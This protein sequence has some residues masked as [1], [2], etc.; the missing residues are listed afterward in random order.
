[1]HF[2]IPQT[3]THPFG[4]GF[5][6]EEV[7]KKMQPQNSNMDLNQQENIAMKYRYAIW[8]NP[9]GLWNISHRSI[10]N[11][12][13]L[14]TF[15]K[16]I[17]HTRSVF[18]IAE[19]YFTRRRRIS[20]KK[21]ITKAIVFFWWEMV[22]TLRSP[23][24]RMFRTFATK[25]S[26]SRLHSPQNLSRFCGCFDWTTFGGSH[27][28]SHIS[29]KQKHTHSGAFLFGGRWWIRTTEGEASRF[30]VCP[31]WPLGKSP[32]LSF[33]TLTATSLYKSD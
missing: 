27:L 30:T 1:M 12:I 29:P 31:L 16:Q 8:N 3:K 28:T 26:Y 32:I 20:L 2:T 6:C 18:H 19:Q 9:Y 24:C 14:S 21:T 11:K 17:F 7:T 33:F 25:C 13:R 5:V 10:R 4:C 23:L 15:A 22:D